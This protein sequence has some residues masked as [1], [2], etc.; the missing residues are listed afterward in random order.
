MVA[1]VFGNYVVAEYCY[2]SGH[3]GEHG[4]GQGKECQEARQRQDRRQETMYTRLNLLRFS[5]ERERIKQTMKRPKNALSPLIIHLSK[6]ATPPT[7]PRVR[8]SEGLDRDR[9]WSTM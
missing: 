5:D 7:S 1:P 8:E 9:A 2:D 4:D 3:G 6:E